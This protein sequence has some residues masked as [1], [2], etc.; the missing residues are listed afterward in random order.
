MS[1]A[2]QVRWLAVLGLIEKLF[3]LGSEKEA[4]LPGPGIFF[5]TYVLVRD[6]LQ[7]KSWRHSSKYFGSYISAQ[8][9]K[10]NIRCFLVSGSIGIAGGYIRHLGE[11]SSFLISEDSFSF[12]D[13]AEIFDV[14][15]I[16]A[17]RLVERE[18]FIFG[19][20]P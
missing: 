9:K 4:Y 13:G 7:G 19:E 3:P 1:Y 17:R 2:L 10:W 14:T 20:R 12:V 15:D 5:S 8:C 18:S 16:G 11:D 6:V